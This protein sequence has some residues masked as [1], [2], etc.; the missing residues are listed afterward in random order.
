MKIGMPPFWAVDGG[1]SDSVPAA[2]AAANASAIVFRM[3]MAF[4]A[5]QMP[6]AAR[7]ADGLT[8]KSWRATA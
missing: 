1:M 5:E 3:A 4:P 8:S 7:P 6:A 2:R